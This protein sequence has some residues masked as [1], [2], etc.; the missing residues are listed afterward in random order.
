M[1]T[2]IN[3][4]ENAR[5]G[6]DKDGWWGIRMGCML[7]HDTHSGNILHQITC[8]QGHIPYSGNTYCIRSQ[9]VFCSFYLNCIFMFLLYS[10]M[11]GG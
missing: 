3:T 8:M 1:K 2:K 9:K 6:C 7:D 4:S 10:L 5:D 11:G